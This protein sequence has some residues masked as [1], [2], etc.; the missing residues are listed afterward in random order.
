MYTTEE[1][2]EFS[3]TDLTNNRDSCARIIARA[4]VRR[5]TETEQIQNYVTTFCKLEGEIQHRLS[6]VGLNVEEIQP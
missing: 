1:I 3:N 2:T 4:A 5:N 6:Q